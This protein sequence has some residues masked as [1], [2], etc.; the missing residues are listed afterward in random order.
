MYLDEPPGD[1]YRSM[2]VEHLQ[3]ATTVESV[4][5]WLVHRLARHLSV[6]PAAIDVDQYFDEL[7]LDSAEAAALAAEL[8]SWLG[9]DLERSAFWYH[10]TIASLA[11]H[12]A[13]ETAQ[14][15]AA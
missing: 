3:A 9:S 15:R 12:I 8:E 4:Q 5:S 2:S 7:D 14:R 6:H 10:P 11:L 13:G 1:P